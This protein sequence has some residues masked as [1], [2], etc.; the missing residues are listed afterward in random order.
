MLQIARAYNQPAPVALRPGSW[1]RRCLCT[2]SILTSSLVTLSYSQAEELAEVQT[3]QAELSTNASP[4][5]AVTINGNRQ[6]AATDRSVTVDATGVVTGLDHLSGAQGL[7]PPSE[8]VLIQLSQT[9]LLAVS[10][11]PAPGAMRASSST[12]SH[13]QSIANEHQ[14]ARAA[15]AAAFASASS[16]ATQSPQAPA[17]RIVREFSAAFNGFA[18]RGISM[19]AAQ[20]SLA[21][22]PG[23]TIYPDV[24]VRASLEE[25]VQIIR[26]AE[27]WQPAHGL[28]LDGTGMT[29]GI[30]D[31]G[32]DYTH[33]DLG[34][35]F[36]SGCKVAG[37]YDFVNND[38]NPVDD[39]GHGTH[40]AAT[41]A[42][43]GS[44]RDSNGITRPL[45]GIAPG[46]TIFAYKVLSAGG[47]GSGSDIIAAIERCADPNNDGSTSD[48]LD[49]CSL[50]LGGGG[51]PDDPMS[52][53][54]DIA[55]AHG[56]VFTVAAGNSGPSAGTVNSP[57]TAREAITVAAACK[58]GSSSGSCA[59]SAIA[60]FSS[61][62]PIP[63]FPLV[64]KPDVSAP[65]VDIC[66]ARF[67]SYA[68]GREC[69]DS[70]H[71]SISGTSMATPQVAGVA[72]IIRQANPG[73]SPADVKAILI[74]TA[75]D[76]GEAATAQGAG[77]VN[78]VAAVAA[79]GQ[80]QAFL[81]F[82]GGVPLV[83]Y[84]PTR[85]IQSHTSTVTL[86]NTSGSPLSV[87]PSAPSAPAGVSVSF[88]SGPITLPVDGRMTVPLALS[89]DH[90]FIVATRTIIPLEF[91][92]PLGAA[93]ISLVLD[94]SSPLSLSASKL[95]FGVGAP[96]NDA[97]SAARSVT[98]TNSLLDA[99]LALSASLAAW[100]SEGGAP[101]RFTSS[102][103]ASSLTV[104]AGGS[105]SI[106]VNTSIGGSAGYNG[107]NTSSLSIS[108][109]GL[110][111]TLPMS[112]WQGYAINVS[113]GPT[114]PWLVRLGSH[115]PAFGSSAGERTGFSPDP[116]SSSSRI[117]VRTAG[118]WD[119]ASLFSDGSSDALVLKTVSV[120]G[121]ETFVETAQREATV[122]LVSKV[123]EISGLF[124]YAWSFAPQHGGRELAID[125]LALD[126]RGGSNFSIATNP[127]GAE[128]RFSAM[129]GIVPAFQGDSSKAPV[130]L[131]FH[132]EGGIPASLVMDP[133]PLRPYQVN[134]V[135]QS[136]PGSTPTFT[137]QSGIKRLLLD[138]SLDSL[139]TM[140]SITSVPVGETLLVL[141]S[142]YHSS[143]PGSS[144]AADLPFSSIFFG[145]SADA[146]YVSSAMT[147][148]A[149]GAVA[150]DEDRFFHLGSTENL[151]HPYQFGP[152]AYIGPRLR[153]LE[154]ADVITLGV[155]PIFD[156]SRWYNVGTS[157]A[158]LVPRTGVLSS[159][160]SCSGTS[161]ARGLLSSFGSD[162]VEP[163]PQ[164][165]LERDGSPIATGTIGE[166][167]ICPPH[168]LLTCVNFGR[169]VH[170]LTLPEVAGVVPPGRYSF[171]MSRDATILGVQTQLSTSSEFSIAT[172]AEHAIA[173]I[174][175][176]P[177]SLLDLNV[178]AGGLRQSSIDP[179]LSNTISFSLDPN[180]GLGEL[181][182]VPGEL[183][184]QQ[185]PDSLAN[186]KL[187]QS[188]NSATWQELQLQSLGSGGFSGLALVRPGASL[189]HFRIEAEDSAGNRFTHSFSLP[190]ASA[191]VLRNPI[192]SPL[193]VSLN[194]FSNNRSY[195]ASREVEVTVLA[196]NVILGSKVELVANG[197]AV[198][199][200]SFKPSNAGSLAYTGLLR[201]SDLPRGK[202]TLHARV[203]DVAGRQADSASKTITILNSGDDSDGGAL[204]LSIVKPG[205]LRVG[206]RI[207]FTIKASG[208]KPSALSN[209]AV[210]ANGKPACRFS[211]VPYT[212]SW[213]VPRT[214]RFSLRLRA[215]GLDPQGKLIRS[216]MATLRVAQ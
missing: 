3:V 15:L 98:L 117:L 194:G 102:L 107:P 10:Q 172:A 173:T 32:V 28:S 124:F 209:V 116:G 58:P 7:E 73:L 92:T 109:S 161:K 106:S 215:R 17:P 199:L 45:P 192:N 48:H 52:R 54:I 37:G 41:A 151:E 38:P 67:G 159:F 46:A 26:A 147:F 68:P 77:M 171:S 18:V 160:Y 140:N 103:S 148:S 1:L 120:I 137:L 88:P 56:V 50:S 213:T 23:V 123:P 187:Y 207:R 96:E 136:N 179:S 75:T 105:I 189:Y 99:P 22:M 5:G 21:S 142:G 112:V 16:S 2:L 139:W 183:H 163:A 113:Y 57:G 59:G 138:R 80:P 170:Q 95:D 42:G 144:S 153:P 44:Y 100:R 89:V 195:S 164:Y 33:P 162:F 49:V 79:A 146:E 182:N 86:V 25:S 133:G 150:Y 9:P 72:A 60:R 87:S 104:P 74:G 176:N 131:H 135:S 193:Q 125:S 82:Q 210:M 132:H 119:I 201:L 118:G 85:L 188:E 29:I 11:K 63:D 202:V 178:V 122:S 167:W 51:T 65:G 128:W 78:A 191:K 70:T 4:L 180:P 115:N 108:G 101:S 205:R 40:V 121:A 214:P 197:S 62:G 110:A 177:P 111:A 19:A 165:T 76:L 216:T 134:A 152:T 181:V 130:L 154:R 145:N 186:V 211:S 64:Q 141:A 84:T 53:A 8:G 91:S 174:D 94:I 158:A 13:A 143:P 34:G 97:F 184:H 155:G 83:R 126:W 169:Q 6:T 208:I 43:S 31:T 27:V 175:E 30:I 66:A 71:I 93:S 127:I 156:R 14:Q 168:A 190:S 20:K 206:S 35:C 55:T 39:H 166:Q 12:V 198:Q 114:N 149:S 36:G 196:Q 47:W 185:L 203:T 81:R 24:P 61:R 204:S 157:A 200:A 69:K 129:A 212:C 90:Q